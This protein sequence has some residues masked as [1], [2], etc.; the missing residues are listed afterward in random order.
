MQTTIF[1]NDN[2]DIYFL[3]FL[4]IEQLQ[5]YP[6]LSKSSFAILKKSN[7]YAETILYQKKYKKLTINNIC[8]L[9]CINMLKLC[10]KSFL[11]IN[12]KYIIKIL[13]NN[14]QLNIIK[15]LI[16]QKIISRELIEENINWAASNG[17]L[18]IVKYVFFQGLESKLNNNFALQLAANY[19]H[20]RVIKYFITYGNSYD[21]SYYIHWAIRNGHL[22]SVKYLNLHNKKFKQ[23]INIICYAAKKDYLQIIKYLALYNNTNRNKFLNVLKII[24]FNGYSKILRYLLYLGV[25]IKDD[26]LINF[27]IENGSIKII[28]YLM[29]SM[30]NIRLDQT[31]S[32]YNA[33]SNGHLNIVKYLFLQHVNCKIDITSIEKEMDK[34]E[35]IEFLYDCQTETKCDNYILYLAVNNNQIDIIKYL[36]PRIICMPIE[37]NYLINFAENKKYITILNYLS[38]SNY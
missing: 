16:H 12:Y 27:A 14:N 1:C 34:I 29:Y 35:D 23:D 25:K 18:D 24:V 3:N 9:G 17:H 5:I 26:I 10:M 31:A 13:M 6:V 7:Y 15:Y 32:L 37:F 4:S 33:V 20:L 21:N 28:K 30:S 11:N 19:G 22:D 36:L 2:L 8:E 38:L